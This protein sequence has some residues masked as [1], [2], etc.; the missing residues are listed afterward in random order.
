ML[1]NLNQ[2]K[3]DAIASV[4]REALN[5]Y[6]SARA[7]T[8]IHVSFY[9]YVGINHTIRFREGEIFVRIGDICREM[10]M[11][12]H[13]GLAHI[14]VGKLLRRKIPKGA[15]EAYEAY[16]DS[17]HIREVT[18]RSK[19]ERGRKVVTT[20]KGEVYDLESIFDSLNVGYFAG[21]MKKPV[22]TWSAKKT[23]RILGHHDSHHDHIAISRSLDSNT[24]PSFVVEYVMY[25]EM[26]H[27]AH[28]TVHINGRHYNHTPAFKR[29][30]R[31]F[32]KFE[33]AEKWIEQNISK[34]KRAARQ[35]PAAKGG[36]LRRL[37][38][39]NT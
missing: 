5:S 38:S 18:S 30:E 33:E 15:R 39:K 35:K 36:L 16:I 37:I 2:P 7:K 22:L 27:I 25:H 3:I 13:R 10:P 29:D 31:R 34:L 26:L 1:N 11:V 24:V 28:P 20:S 19:R 4:Y 6:D 21:Q 14:L 32:P 9:P 23:Y 17:D 8:P 12:C